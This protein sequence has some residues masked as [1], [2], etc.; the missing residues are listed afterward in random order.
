MDPAIDACL[1]T[2]GRKME[3]AAS[4]ETDGLGFD[5]ETYAGGRGRIWT[6]STIRL[7]EVDAAA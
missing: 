3:S 6:R 7:E 5:P 4:P 2:S 1:R